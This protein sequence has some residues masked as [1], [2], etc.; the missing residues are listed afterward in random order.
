MQINK[1]G[2]QTI[3][4]HNG[5]KITLFW[6]IFMGR[7]EVFFHI[8]PNSESGADTFDMAPEVTKA[9]IVTDKERKPKRKEHK[10]SKGRKKH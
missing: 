4:F 10:K 9:N 3:I 8:K 7:A 5:K 1:K 2:K 6:I